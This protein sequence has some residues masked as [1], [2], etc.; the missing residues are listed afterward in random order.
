MWSTGFEP[1]NAPVAQRAGNA[2]I[3]WIGETEKQGITKSWVAAPANGKPPGNRCGSS[4]PCHAWGRAELLCRCASGVR[5]WCPL[6]RRPI[7]LALARPNGAGKTISKGRIGGLGQVHR[8][9]LCGGIRSNLLYV[10]FDLG[11]QHSH[12]ARERLDGQDGEHLV[13]ITAALGSG[14][15][16]VGSVPTI[17]QFHHGYGRK[18]NEQT[19]VQD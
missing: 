4:P 10:R 8:F 3:S 15:G 5:A 16:C 6:D 17:F 1:L 12:F 14:F 9:P 7:L 13:Q 11:G 2:A 19:R 18:Q